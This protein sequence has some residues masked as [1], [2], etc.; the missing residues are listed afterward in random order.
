MKKRNKKYRPKPVADT[1][2]IRLFAMKEDFEEIENVFYKLKTGEVLEA[3]DPKNGEWVLVYKKADGTICY[4]LQVATEWTNFFSELAKH[5]L[6]SYDDK[7][8]RKLITKLRIGQNLDIET[9]LEAEK[10][11]DIQRKLFLMADAKVYNAIGSRVVDDFYEFDNRG[12]QL[13]A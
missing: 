13:A 1:R 5:Y 3:K 2:S 7:P 4:L 11:L 10:V 12:Q 8:M 9:V 6:P